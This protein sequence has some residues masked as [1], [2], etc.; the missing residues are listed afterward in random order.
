M[1]TIAM[2]KKYKELDYRFLKL[3]QLYSVFAELRLHTNKGISKETA[4]YYYK[5]LYV[6]GDSAPFLTA[7]LESMMQVFYIELEGFIGAYW[8]ERVKA[9]KPKKKNETG[10]L[11][12]YLY[13]GKWASRKKEAIERFEKLLK[14]EA[15]PLKKVNNTRHKLAHFKKLSERNKAVVP[16]DLE[17][18]RVLNGLAE[19]LYLLGFQRWNKPHYIDKNDEP[20]KSVQQTIDML[21]SDD[22]KAK[23]IRKEYLKSRDNWYSN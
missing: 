2:T 21:V 7:S 1:P 5:K 13:D 20:T 6:W 23:T 22:E 3:T 16:N 12:V 19:V 8:D 14:E 10:S 9:F 18:R 11:G 4:D 15:V 17:T